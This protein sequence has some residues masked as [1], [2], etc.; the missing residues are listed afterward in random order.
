MNTV[1][2]L[3][4]LRAAK[5]DLAMAQALLED[6]F[7]HGCAF[8]AQQAA[9]KSLKGL[10]YAFNEKLWGHR[11]F[12][13][14]GQVEAFLPADAIPESMLDATHRLDEHYLP[15][16]YPDVLPEGIPS[17]QYDR[18]MAEQAIFDACSILEFVEER[19]R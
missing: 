14:L 17:E 13:L 19:M 8:H 10:L 9:E 12:E 11:T 3:R 4:W 5:S 7:Y 6:E 18:S 16:R 1:E 2:G 15:S